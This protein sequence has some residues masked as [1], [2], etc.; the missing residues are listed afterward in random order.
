LAAISL[1]FGIYYGYQE[2]QKQ[3]LPAIALRKELIGTEY[4]RAVASQEQ[5]NSL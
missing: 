1:E 3:I 2:T 5:Q 4:F